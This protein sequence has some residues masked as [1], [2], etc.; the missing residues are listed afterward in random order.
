MTSEQFERWKD[1]AT[2]MARTCFKGHRRPSTRQI[3]EM[4]AEFF[5]D[6]ETGVI[7]HVRGI[8]SEST[9]V[10]SVDHRVVRRFP[11]I[12]TGDGR[13]SC[14]VPAGPFRQWTP[15]PFFRRD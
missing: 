5:A 15:A 4:A 2:R 7:R 3:V 12:E 6:I 8:R 10:R 11:L 9:R 1:F 14:E 13:P